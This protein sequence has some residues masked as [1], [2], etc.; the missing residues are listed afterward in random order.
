MQARRGAL[1]TNRS[2]HVAAPQG[3]T[4]LSLAS[5]TGTS[6][7]R[8]ASHDS[9]APRLDS[10]PPCSG[11]WLYPSVSARLRA[12]QQTRPAGPHPHLLP[13]VSGLGTTG[14]RGVIELDDVELGAGA[15]R[16]SATRSS[17]AR[18]RSDRAP[19]GR[20]RPPTRTGRRRNGPSP[21]RRPRTQSPSRPSRAGTS[22]PATAASLLRRRLATG[23]GE[24]AGPSAT[25]TALLDSLDRAGEV[26]RPTVEFA[27][28]CADPLDVAAD[29]LAQRL[30]A[31]AKPLSEARHVV[32]VTR[33]GSRVA[34]A[35]ELVLGVALPGGHVRKVPSN[36]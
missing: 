7:T 5:S 20:S 13:R 21:M 11:S 8:S 33:S 3:S 23:V 32:Q 35:R 6:R 24:S 27:C 4:H 36:K 2:D 9:A 30:G 10:S 25:S 12:E 1:D 18:R 17:P 22:W 31:H 29:R 34:R 28:G 26:D 19:P 16:M 15:A 14:R